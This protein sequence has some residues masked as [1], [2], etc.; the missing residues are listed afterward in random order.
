M[1]RILL[2]EIFDF[3]HIY[4]DFSM[5]VINK[6]QTMDRHH[7][8]TLIYVHLHVQYITFLKA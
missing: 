7:A 3:T 2:V 6:R 5:N 1:N 4:V 8:F